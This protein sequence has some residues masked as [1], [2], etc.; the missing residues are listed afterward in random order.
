LLQ[1]L[2]PF[3]IVGLGEI[4]VRRHL[5]DLGARLV[6]VPD[7]S[8]AERAVHRERAA[9]PW[10]VERRLVRLRLHRAE[11]FHAAHVVDAVHCAI[12]S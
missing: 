4:L 7:L 9:F 2:R 6:D 12:A 11:S 10:G 5:F 3:L 1:P 8:E